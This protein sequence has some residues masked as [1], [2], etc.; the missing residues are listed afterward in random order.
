[1]LKGVSRQIIELTDSQNPY[2]ERAWLLV[3][4]ECAE[5]PP[6]R[7]EEAGKRL[8]KHTKPHTGLVK[9]R[10]RHLLGLALAATLGAACGYLV[11]ILCR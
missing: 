8:L 2:F 11:N 10:R 1:M 4:A 5:Q 6:E 9:S 7:L 3:R